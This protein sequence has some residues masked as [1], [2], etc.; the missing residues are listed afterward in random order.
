MN[1]PFPALCNECRHATEDKQSPWLHKC[2]HPRVVAAD[3]YALSQNYEGRSAG[4]SCYDQRRKTSWFAPCG[5]RGKLWEPRGAE[6][7]AKGK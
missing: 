4:S 7:A 6:P 1:K 5:I 2:S 3:S